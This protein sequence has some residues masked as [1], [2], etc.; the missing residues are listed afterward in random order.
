MIS[1]NVNLI[2]YKGDGK[3]TEFAIPFPF[4]EKKDIV[5]Y[6][7][8]DDVETLLT[9][10][11]YI[12]AVNNILIYPGYAPGEEKTESEQPEILPEGSRLIITR[13][14]DINQERN[15]GRIWPFNETEK[16][17]DKLTLICQDM[18]RQLNGTAHLSTA[19]EI[20][21][22]DATFPYPAEG[23]L[24]KWHNGKLVNVD[25]GDIIADPTSKLHIR[26][27][28]NVAEMK[29]S[30]TAFAGNPCMTLGYYEA[31][32]GGGALYIIRS[33]KDGDVDDGGSIIVLNNG[34]V[35]ELINSEIVNVKQFGAK[36]DGATDDTNCVQNALNKGK[37]IIFPSGTYEI[38]A[39]TTLKLTD[40]ENIHIIINKDAEI[41]VIT[42][43][44]THY[45][46][47]SLLRCSNVLIDGGGKVTGDMDTHTGTDGEWGYGFRIY[48]CKKVVIRDIEIQ[49]M[50]GDGIYVGD[51]ID[52]TQCENVLIQRCYIHNNRRQGISI[53]YVNGITVD[54]CLITNISG[55][56]PQSGI[57][58]ELEGNASTLIAQSNIVIKNT[59]I[60]DCTGSALQIWGD[61]TYVKVINCTSNGTFTIG[62]NSKGPVELDGCTFK[63]AMISDASSPETYIRDCSFNKLTH[64][65]TVHLFNCKIYRIE[66]LGT[67][68]MHGGSLLQLTHST[69]AVVSK[70]YAN[71]IW[72]GD[73]AG[74][75][76]DSGY[77]ALN[78][79]NI[80]I[81]FKNSIIN[82]KNWD[83]YEAIFG[84]LIFDSCTIYLHAL[85]CKQYNKFQIV[86]CEIIFETRGTNNSFIALLG[87]GST[88]GITIL[89]R[90]LIDLDDVE[91][92]SSNAA[93]IYV[94]NN[95]TIIDNLIKIA[96][97]VA[98][99][100][101]TDG[102]KSIIMNNVCT[103]ATQIY[104]KGNDAT[105]VYV[106]GNLVDTT[107][108]KTA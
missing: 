10:D 94:Y 11:Y 51:Y 43:D 54:E 108:S 66:N 90:N 104:V 19:A 98:P 103:D 93:M 95:A 83:I 78:S 20:D 87:S 79:T 89:N 17:L 33:K 21:G 75:E 80:S 36:G 32:D 97:K 42:N 25:F 48:N 41:K 30:D 59:T 39:V 24:I 52:G 9:D 91:S 31:S 107:T 65:N 12:D 5:A 6:I 3:T 49:K 4:I 13:D 1:T 77:L 22:F 34:N 55:T 29:A 28:T 40:R 72:F 57:D 38:N 56:W 68:Y 85:N 2:S 18:K 45:F 46:A 61:A 73:G 53:C 67:C 88:D 26:Y 50:W 14:I 16:G 15:L 71:N 35:A 7:V 8:K 101:L 82:A 60:N 37:T 62:K 92:N 27:Y 74:G 47:F 64:Q 76:S 99:P 63:A 102:A 105:T 81:I 58:V 86:N 96:H 23:K 70:F 44:S 69:E 106:S 84:S 100:F